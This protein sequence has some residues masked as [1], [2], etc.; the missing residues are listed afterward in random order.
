MYMSHHRP[1]F[2]VTATYKLMNKTGFI[3]SDKE[4][5]TITVKHFI[6]NGFVTGKLYDDR[7][8]LLGNNHMI[9][10]RDLEKF[11]IRIK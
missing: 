3:K 7:V 2:P 5:N 6:K 11:F 1:D 4:D 8:L 9:G 10:R